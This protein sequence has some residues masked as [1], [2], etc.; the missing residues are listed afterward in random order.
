MNP[1]LQTAGAYYRVRLIWSI[2]WRYVA[3]AAAVAALLWLTAC[4]M[5][6][7]G[8]S[9]DQANRDVYE[10]N[11]EARSIN[12]GAVMDAYR[13]CMHARGYK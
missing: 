9:Q 5:T 13:D 7:A 8:V 1:L 12:R 3:M 10:C 6:K 2:A 11:R 4:T